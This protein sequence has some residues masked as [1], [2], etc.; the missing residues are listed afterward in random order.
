MLSFCRARKGSSG[1]FQ[2]LR[3]ATPAQEAFSFTMAEL[4]QK[5]LQG[6]VEK[7]QQL[8]KGERAELA[9]S[10]PCPLSTMMRHRAPSGG[11]CVQRTAPRFCILSFF[12][13]TSLPRIVRFWVHLMFFKSC[14]FLSPPQT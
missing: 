13:T 4:I 6:E 12:V 5:K 11:S 9:W 3:Q 8:Q 14:I 7:Y 1:A 2:S 10:C